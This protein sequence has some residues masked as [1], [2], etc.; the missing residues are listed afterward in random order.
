MQPGRSGQSLG[1]PLLSSWHDRGG[2]SLVLSP[3]SPRLVLHPAAGPQM[4]CR[5]A[6]RRAGCSSLGTTPYTGR[7]CDMTQSSHGKH[8]TDPPRFPIPINHQI[9]KCESEEDRQLLR[10]AKAI[11]DD[12]SVAA[13]IE[14]GRLHLIKDAC[15][16]YSLG[17]VQ[18]LV[19]RAIDRAGRNP[20]P[21]S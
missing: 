7:P 5:R 12:P 16:R 14:I 6:Y 9:V 21:N 20:P 4:L 15:Q 11:V 17:A 10:G 8:M 1:L 2:V 18:R 13:Q 19:K 3:S